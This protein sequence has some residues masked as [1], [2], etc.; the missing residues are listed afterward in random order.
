MPGVKALA[1]GRP[2]GEGRDL[3]SQEAKCFGNV[4]VLEPGHLEFV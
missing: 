4:K 3:I 1:V 2:E